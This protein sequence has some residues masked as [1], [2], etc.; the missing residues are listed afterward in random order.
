M[1]RKFN[2]ENERIKRR[3]RHF[4]REAK[5]C[6]MATVDK[7]A[8]A[9]LRFERST[10]F[11]PFKRFHIDQAM[12]FKQKLAAEK[13]ARTGAPLSKATIDSTLR[14]VK[15]FFLWLAG[16][17][18]YKSR[19]AYADAQYFNLNAKDARVA[20][21]Q[22]DTPFPTPEQ[23]RHA[24][25]QMP[26]TTPLQRRDKALF[27]FLM[28]TGA[29][30]G[31]VASM[32]LKRIDL[33]ENCVYQDARDVKT[34][35]AK[36]FTTWFYPV[37]DAYL[38]TFRAWVDFLRKDQLFGPEDALFPKPLMGVRNGSFA[39]LG[40]SR[41]TYSN[42]GKIRVVIKD[43]FTGAGL[44]SFHPH[45]FR[46]TLGVMSND[47]CKTPEQFKAWSL[48]MG[49]ENIA[50]TLSAYCPVSSQRQGQLIRGMA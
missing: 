32:R 41:D 1:T 15:A 10:G 37:D 27:A 21:A 7:A 31:A 47:H 34:K 33:V 24:F 11:K 4:L 6:D 19:I 14:A 3:Y 20:H 29:R 22:R 9:I 46:K 38:D 28:L 50:T 36:T 39:C 48:N 40:L 26:A 16:Q 2:E 43:A 44:P 13:N 8:D 49:H 42:A 35:G 5:G 25:D 12:T 18:G 30:D 17:P 45:S 23:A